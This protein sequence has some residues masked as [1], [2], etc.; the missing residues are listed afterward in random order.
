LEPALISKSKHLN[1]SEAFGNITSVSFDDIYDHAK[2]DTAL[3]Q[4]VAILRRFSFNASAGR[5]T[6]SF[7]SDLAAPNMED[8]VCDGQFKVVYKNAIFQPV[9]KN[10]PVVFKVSKEA[11]DDRLVFEKCISLV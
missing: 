10:H 4:S 5:W 2:S 7:L 6:E 8:P 1:F 9:F 3:V 11:A